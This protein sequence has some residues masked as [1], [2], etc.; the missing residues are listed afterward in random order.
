M[1]CKDLMKTDIECVSATDTVQE[2]A[3]RMR[4]QNV[5]FLPV[6]DADDKV[7][8]TITDRD[9]AIRIA[10]AAKPATTPV[11]D[12][13]TQEVVACGPEDDLQRAHQLM[14]KN[15]KSRIMCVDEGGVLVGVISL[16]DIVQGE[17]G[18]RAADTL[19]KVSEREARH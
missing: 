19:R 12:A 3:A 15:R 10:A 17:P 5:G 1:L 7:L 14:A 2:A 16:S 8:G 13:M 6:C 4:D 18:P 9:I 11:A